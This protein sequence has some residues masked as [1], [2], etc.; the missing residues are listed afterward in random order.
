M[1]Q[2]LG[3]CCLFF[4]L[5]PRGTALLDVPDGA[6]VDAE[7]RAADVVGVRAGEVDDGG[8]DLL[9]A[10]VAIAFGCLV[11]ALAPN[12][13]DVSAEVVAG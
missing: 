6:A 2:V 10:L 12:I 5:K 1:S 7:R 11:A 9:G 13:G 8:R 3:M 4:L